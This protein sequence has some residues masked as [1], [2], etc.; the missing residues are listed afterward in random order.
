MSRIVF[1]AGVSHS[2]LLTLEPED[3]LE[4]SKA[5]IHN[6]ALNL[7]DGRRLN[8]EQLRAEIGD[9]YE[10]HCTVENFKKQ[11]AKCQNALDR[12]SQ[13]LEAA[14]PDVVIIVGDDQRELFGA[15]NQPAVAV[16]YGP[17]IKMTDKIA[18]ENSSQWV[19][20]MAQGY[21]MDDIHVWP[22]AP[23][24]GFELISK[25][26]D[27]GVDATVLANIANPSQAG[28]GHAFGFV[29]KRLFNGN[30]YPVLPLLL[31]TYYPPNVPTAE[32]SYDLGVALYKAVQECGADTRVAVI[33]SGGLSH[34]VVDE[35]LDR[36]VL[37]WLKTKQI[38]SLQ[39][40]PRGALNSGSSEILNWILT[41]G[42]VKDLPMSWFEYEPIYR[43]AAGTGIGAA[44]AVWAEE[45]K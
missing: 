12:T 19:Q 20:T 13:E 44:F 23:H 21:L 16:Y 31:N 14:A 2:P 10:E 42:A 25:L 1:G 11:G 17:E 6:S 28:F 33:A 8:Y 36:S 18:L 43:T 5:D 37:H 22:G 29:I 9:R 41:A 3:W 39:K 27:H 45:T 7:S 32:R 30:N 24:F 38:D 34:F 40:I 15:D 4:R 26:V 35:E